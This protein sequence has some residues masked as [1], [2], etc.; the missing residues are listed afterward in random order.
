MAAHVHR[1]AYAVR[2]Y[3]LRKRVIVTWCSGLTLFP[4][5]WTKA[6]TAEQFIRYWHQ[7][8]GYTK[9]EQPKA[10]MGLTTQW[11]LAT[12]GIQQAPTSMCAMYIKFF[13]SLPHDRV[14]RSVRDASMHELVFVSD[15]N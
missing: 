9:F 2:E 6:V 3:V 7:M 11:L 14:N 4:D 15:V 8:C 5:A 1:D 13:N 12:L 10:A